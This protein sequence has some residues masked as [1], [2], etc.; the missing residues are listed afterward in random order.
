MFH[1]IIDPST[2]RPVSPVWR[3]V[4]VAAWRCLDA[5]IVSK[6]AIVR[7]VRATRWLRDIGLPA[8]LVT[9]GAHE[10]ITLNGWPADVQVP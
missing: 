7:G 1:H 2:G 4:S 3:T 10:I 9:R 6:A 8:R 5:N